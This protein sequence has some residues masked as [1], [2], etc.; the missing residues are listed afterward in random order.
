MADVTITIDGIKVTVPEGTYAIDAAKKIGIDIP[1]FCYLP[2]LRAFGACRMCIVEVKGRKGWD[3]AISC[4]TPAKEGT[5]I[6]TLTDQVWEQRHMIME[7]L[8]VD[9]PL[10]CPICEAN[11]DCR[12]QDYG[13]DYGVVGTELRRPKITR[14]AERLSPAID[15]DR[16][17]C[18]VCGRCVRSCDEQ[19]GAVAL[20]FVQ[21][22][23][24]TVIDAPFGKSLLDTP[25][26]S[27]GTCV[28]VCPVGALSS[29]LYAAGHYQ[30]H[31]M[32]RKTRTTCHY[33]GVG[34]QMHIGTHNNRVYEVRTADSVGL[35]DGIICVKGRF[36]QDALQNPDRLSLPMIRQADGTF[37]TVPW[38]DALDLMA[39]RLNAHRGA[40]G[41][42]ASPK[43][44]N[45]ELYLM[46]KVVRA[47]LGTN[48]ID[49][50]ARYPEAD[51][52]AVL[53]EAF[54]FPAMTNNLLDTRQT[55][56]C[57][58]AV[59]DSIYESHPVYAYQLQR[60]I[61]LR[62]VNLVVISPHP[63]KM[64]EWATLTLAPPAGAE[65]LLLAGIA[66]IIL[67]ENLA[68]NAANLPDL[69]GWQ[70]SLGG[71]TP[72]Q[73]STQTGVPLDDMRQA[74]YLYATGG[75]MSKAGKTPNDPAAQYPPSAIL[76]P[77]GAPYVLDPGAVRQLCN[78]ATITGNVGRVGGGVNPLVSENNTMGLNDMGC[79]PDR[80]PGY[81]PITAEN[82]ARFGATSPFADTPRPMPTDPG[83]TVPQMM[84]S[85]AD[86]TI[87]A[88]W[89]VGAN[90]VLNAP[91]PAAAR[92]AL[93]KLDFLVV[94]DLYMNE[95][96]ELAH[97]ILPASSYLE[98]DGTFTNTERRIQ[99]V[100]KACEP[101]GL[102]RP[103]GAIFIEMGYRLG[104]PM[105]Y[106]RSTDVMDEISR[107]VPIYSGVNYGRL[108][109]TQYI[110]DAIPMPG[111]ISYKQLR[112]Q[113]LQWPVNG[114][115]H[116][117][118]PVLPAPAQPKLFPVS[119][120]PQAAPT[121]AA[122]TLLLTTGF[123][124]FPFQTGTLSRRSRDLAAVQPK[125]RLLL[126]SAD[127][128]RLGLGDTQTVRISGAGIVPP[129]G[130]SN[131]DLPVEAITLV[132]ERTPPGTA[133]LRTTLEQVGRSALVRQSLTQQATGREGGGK[134]IPVRV[135]YEP[136]PVTSSAQ[137]GPGP[138]VES[139]L[140]MANAA[141]PPA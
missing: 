71:L 42:I 43:L 87:K 134:A 141:A 98:K 4:G 17:R 53:E 115:R 14:P 113:G 105:P 91:D 47:G 41:A 32:Q 107:V 76:F 46:Q 122:G 109:M 25:C 72:E 56:G 11:G 126:N 80:L 84:Q 138:S 40:V 96:A 137:L 5:E 54:G 128:A 63:V 130:G 27:C 7:L 83:L 114:A 68:T 58:L 85:A 28:E 123:S 8:D 23:I 36:A 100:R 90:P 81:L 24:E 16:D 19:I 74:A 26:T 95:T 93:Q 116:G 140:D 110:E 108:E 18:V 112:I 106:P 117:G 82:A 131:G 124:L 89:I 10:D 67:A 34:C 133:Y 118:T 15:I 97:V 62:D 50:P 3:L 38:E 78:L 51:G 20:A 2:G 139:V 73:V 135:A 33:C 92:A 44:T 52:L 61:R 75:K 6:R 1:N 45:E 132:D 121:L 37:Q 64:M 77:A 111:A 29:R 104:L 60:L 136:N 94:Q 48:N 59:G 120:P 66:A 127:A 21:R 31:W 79:R 99:R 101:V 129:P 86:G 88:L 65:E 49:S 39:E 103:D 125:A 119:A 30:H 57:I 69:A 55:A 70:A 9:H 102:S 35:N 22:G 12:L 13:Y